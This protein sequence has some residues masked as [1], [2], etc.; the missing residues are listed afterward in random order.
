MVAIIDSCPTEL[1][2][3]VMNIGALPPLP[4]S[5]KRLLPA[6]FIQR[7]SGVRSAGAIG[8]KRMATP[9]ISGWIRPILTFEQGDAGIAVDDAMWRLRIFFSQ[10]VTAVAP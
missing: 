2:S 4:T 10:S 1:K 3:Y 7:C 5:A 8:V 6:P 9:H